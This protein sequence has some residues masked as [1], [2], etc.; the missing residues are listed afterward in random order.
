MRGM[1]HFILGSIFGVLATIFCG[2]IV[3]MSVPAKAAE[4]KKEVVIVRETKKIDKH[5]LVEAFIQVESEGNN[6]AVNKVSGATGCLQ[7]TDTMILEAN[8]LL[9][10]NKY[11]LSDRTNRRKSIEIF[12]VIMQHKNPEYD[13]HL[14]CKIWSPRGK[15]SYHTKVVNKYNEL[16]NKK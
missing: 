13:I 16:N 15:L 6:R 9:G 11:K 7:L 8:R 4:M 10:R 12:H 5:K 3:Y 2:A 1:K 14:A